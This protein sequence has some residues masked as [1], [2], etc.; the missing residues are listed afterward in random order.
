MC[1]MPQ[2][3]VHFWLVFLSWRIILQLAPTCSRVICWAAQ[4][5]YCSRKFE[6]LQLEPSLHVNSGWAHITDKL[7]HRTQ[8]GLDMWTGHAV[9]QNTPVL[10]RDAWRQNQRVSVSI[11]KPVKNLPLHWNYWNLF[12]IQIKWFKKFCGDERQDQKTD[13][14]RQIT[15]VQSQK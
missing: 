1:L 5:W 10:H 6:L 2:Q 7:I 3:L 13:R 15:V 8:E 14:R 4:L 9:L 11:S 12:P